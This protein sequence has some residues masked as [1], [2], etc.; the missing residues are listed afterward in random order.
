MTDVLDPPAAPEALDE[1]VVDA[2]ETRRS[3]W[4]R[5]R[6]PARPP[7]EPKPARAPRT[8]WEIVVIAVTI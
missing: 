1:V 2:P 5:L 7:R 8:T 6:L 3:W 4:R